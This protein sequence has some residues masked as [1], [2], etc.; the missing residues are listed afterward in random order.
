METLQERYVPS[1]T[2]RGAGLSDGGDSAD[3]S[4][5]PSAEVQQ[6]LNPDTLSPMAPPP[7]PPPPAWYDLP[8]LLGG[9]ATEPEADFWREAKQGV[10]PAALLPAGL[11]SQTGPG[12]NRVHGGEITL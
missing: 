12:M 5:Q 11:V 8:R 9:G 6:L 4:T 1:P 10:V 3:S 2:A 7:P